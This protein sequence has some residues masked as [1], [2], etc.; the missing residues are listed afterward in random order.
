LKPFSK[1][2]EYTLRALLHLARHPKKRF[3][4]R[5]V[6]KDEGIP[7][8]FTR[9]GLQLLVKSGHINAMRGPQG[10]ISLM[11]SPDS[12][13]LFEIMDIVDGLPSRPPCPLGAAHCSVKKPCAL[14]LLVSDLQAEA[15]ARLK[16]FRL[17]DFTNGGLP[18]LPR[19]KRRVKGSKS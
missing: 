16:A 10:G 14:R 13:T 15:L 1:L 11:T 9:K 5:D 18:V 4:V 2:C 8:H 6:C 12:I 17:K 3:L 7:L 19:K